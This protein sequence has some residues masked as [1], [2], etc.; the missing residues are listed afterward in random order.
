LPAADLLD[1]E[2]IKKEEFFFFEYFLEYPPKFAKGN[3][4]PSIREN[5]HPW[6]QGEKGNELIGWRLRAD[7]VGSGSI[8]FR[9]G[10]AIGTQACIGFRKVSQ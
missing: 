5:Q 8:V 3:A 7:C 1:S 2:V 10:S 9:R 4:E 6:Q